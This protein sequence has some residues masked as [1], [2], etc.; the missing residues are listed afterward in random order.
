MIACTVFILAISIL[1]VYWTYSSNRIDETNRI[2]D[3]IEK[4][5]LISDIW[6]RE[7]IPKYWDVSNVIDIGL[8]NDHR[9]NR[10]KMDSLNDPML[11]Y[12]NVT[13]LIG[14]EVYDYK[15]RV[16]NSTKD[17]VYE[18]SVDSLPTNPDNLIKIKRV[19]ILNGDIVVLEVMIW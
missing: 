5:Y 11:G 3:M 1:F 17:L 8:S 6:F 18:F 16:Y 9:F 13:K 19:G 12:K 2:N 14:I 7:G 15:F 4:A 10:T